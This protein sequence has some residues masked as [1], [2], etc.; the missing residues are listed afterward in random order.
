M[1]NKILIDSSFFIAL[2]LLKDPNHKKAAEIAANAFQKESLFLTNAYIFAESMTMTLL[3]TKDVKWVKKL[4]ESIFE[5]FAKIM[6]IDVID[7]NF[8]KQIY[9]VFINQ[10]KFRGEFLSFA[11]CSLLIQGRNNNLKTIFTFDST[12]LQFSKEFQIVGASTQ[13]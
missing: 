5:Q 1:D 4:K 2:A 12:F 3:R 8:Q 9:Q 11:D 7:D 10:R 6:T 13:N